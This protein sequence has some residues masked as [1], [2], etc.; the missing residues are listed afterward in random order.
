[1]SGRG[2]RPARLGGL[3]VVW[4]GLVLAG[5]LVAFSALA[6]RA[7]PTS[8]NLLN[9]VSD[10]A[11]LLLLATGMT[12]V[13]ITA[14]IDLSVGGVLVFSAVVAARV[15]EGTGSPPLGAAGALATGLAWGVL[16]GVLVALGRIPAL[17]VTLG[18]LGMSLG[19]ALL[20]TGG[21][22]LRAPADLNLGL[23]LARWLGVPLIVW[24]CAAITAVLASRW[25]GPASAAT[26]TPSAPTPRPPGAAA[27]PCAGT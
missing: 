13:I 22:D 26:R 9:L 21:V 17:I 12:F 15:I 24:I 11:I 20:L 19:G 8:F 27:W 16:N 3:Q 23:G 6:P 10:A 7:F 14:G 2:G 25:P 18:T 5:L 4:I 1:M